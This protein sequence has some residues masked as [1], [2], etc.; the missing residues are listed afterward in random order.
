MYNIIQ[1]LVNF[2]KNRPNFL[3]GNAG[4]WFLVFFQSFFFA[5]EDM[6]KVEN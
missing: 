3:Q 5:Q 1:F 4:F 6:G 2:E